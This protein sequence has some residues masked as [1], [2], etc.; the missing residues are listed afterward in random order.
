[1]DEPGFFQDLGSLEVG[2]RWEEPCS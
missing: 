2:W 1:V